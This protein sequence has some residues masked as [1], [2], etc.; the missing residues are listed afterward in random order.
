[1]AERYTCKL[2]PDGK[3]CQFRNLERT[4][5]FR[6]HERDH[7]G[8]TTRFLLALMRV[9]ESDVEGRNLLSRRVI[10]ARNELTRVGKLSG[11]RCTNCPARPAEA[12]PHTDPSDTFE[13]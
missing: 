2:N 7:P 5:A 9:F 13:E 4:I 1:M 11:Q 8:L 12:E 10:V 6:I 3:T